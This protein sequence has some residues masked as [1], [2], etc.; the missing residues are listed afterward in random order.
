M[1]KQIRGCRMEEGLTLQQLSTRSGVAASTIHKVESGQMV[2]TVA[3]LL[4][5]ARGLGRRPDELVRDQA[6]LENAAELAASEPSEGALPQAA[7]DFAVWRVGPAAARARAARSRS[8]AGP[9]CR[10]AGRGGRRARAFPWP[11]ARPRGRRLRRGR[12]RSRASS[13]RSPPN[14]R[15]PHAD[16]SAP[17]PARAAPR[18][19]RLPTHHTPAIG[20]RPAQQALDRRTGAPAAWRAARISIPLGD[21][22]N[23]CEIERLWNPH[24]SGSSFT[25][26]F[27]S[28]I[29]RRLER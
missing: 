12:G 26:P 22:N 27:W 9:A 4:K 16:C 8:G 13:T 1:A 7:R 17:R 15:P 28:D 11:R 5:I 3:I 25:G 21:S 29:V 24:Q 10:A 23:P 20:L 19:A 6:T 18:P 2:P 14:A